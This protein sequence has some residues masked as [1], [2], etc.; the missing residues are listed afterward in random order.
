MVKY[1]GSNDNM[2][3][4]AHQIDLVMDTLACLNLVSAKILTYVVDELDLFAAFS[5][6]L[7]QEIDRLASDSSASPSDDLLEKEA[8][9]DH[10]KVLFY[11]QK[12]MTTSKLSVFFQED[13]SDEQD[14]YWKTA[15]RDFPILEL[16][17]TQLRRQED[18][19]PYEK[20][21][22]KIS[23]LCRHMSR[24]AAAVFEKIAEAEKRNV[25]FGQP[26]LLGSRSQDSPV[27]MRIY[28]Q[29]RIAELLKLKAL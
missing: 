27:A 6:W 9:I 5:A 10:G 11:V 26:T 8:A 21:L 14:K 23:L 16:L 24:Q 28:P 17:D 3:F 13:V 19:L 15:D 7:R 25:L 20:H 12:V 4:S 29:V 2:G 18:G 22:P 1:Q